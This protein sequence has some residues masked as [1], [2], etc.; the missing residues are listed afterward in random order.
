M[1]TPLEDQEAARKELAD[2]KPEGVEPKP[3]AS[4]DTES[5]ASKL[6]ALVRKHGDLIHDEEQNAYALIEIDGHRETLALRSKQFRQ[7]IGH[8]FYRETGIVASTKNVD[9]AITTLTGQAIYD[10]ELEQVFLRVA[11]HAGSYWID[12]GDDQWRA[13]RVNRYGWEIVNHPPVIFRRSS[14]SAALPEPVPGGDIGEISVLVHVVNLVSQ[15]FPLIVAWILESLRP[16]TAFPILELCGE[17]GSAKSTTQDRLRQLIDPNKSNLRVDPHSTKDLFVGASQN[18]VCS[19]NN[20]SHLSDSMQD[21]LC[22]LSTGGG[23]SA[24]TLYS[25]LDETVA[26][27]KRPVVING[28]SVLAHRQDMVD[29]TIRLMLPSIPPAARRTDSELNQEFELIKPRLFGALLNVFSEA[30]KELPTVRLNELP[31][32]A[33]FARFGEAVCR[34]M[35]WPESFEV[36]YARLRREAVEVALDSSP[37]I[38]AL[39]RFFEKRKKYEEPIYDGTIQ[40]LLDLIR[41]AEHSDGFPKAAK[42]LA[43]ILQ[44]VIQRAVIGVVDRLTQ[45][46]DRD[47]DGI[48]AGGTHARNDV[49]PAAVGVEVDGTCGGGGANAPHR[50]HQ[51]IAGHERFSLASLAEAHHSLGDP[52]DMIQGHGRHI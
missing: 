32:M 39:R 35:R 26:D 15:N 18:W 38:V 28:I 40:D 12:M 20:L 21:A 37:A 41:P 27:I 13:V 14:Q 11:K 19:Y 10:G 6:V 3:K 22:C 7:W 45:A 30:L 43:N 33:D 52:A 1:S 31:R 9:D 51:K 29:R 48:Q 23:Y 34:A 47:A 24:R 2:Q 42:G 4:S 46:V 25:D 49:R 36:I 5:A 44:G 50:F 17:Q 8:L 16:D